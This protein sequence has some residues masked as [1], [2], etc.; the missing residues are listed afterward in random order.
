MFK[1]ILVHVPSTQSARPV[2]ECSTSLAAAL[3]A[4]LD[5]VAFG[6]EPVTAEL[7][8]EGAAAVAAVVEVQRERALQEANSALAVF[9]AEAKRSSVPYTCRGYSAMPAQAAE[10]MEGLSRLYDLTVASQP[11]PAKSVYDDVI[12]EA[13][14]FN[15]GGPVLVVPYIHR[16]PFSA[17]RIAI[18]W[19]G[20][21]SA[22]RA[23]R[24]A[25]PFLQQADAVDAL[26][27]NED[28][29]AVE[30]S[31]TALVAHLGRRGVNASAQR[32]TSERANVHN[33]ILSAVADFGTNLLVMGG[34]GHSRLREFVLGGV[35]RG[36]F[37]SMTIPVL[38]S[39]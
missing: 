17:K 19:D 15:S 20:S 6:Y 36:I 16:G 18:C 30:T 34:Y 23:V 12:P 1:H 28:P 22:A 26:S 24:D 32:L 14:L 5:A 27:V 10:T 37:Q 33:T 2:I 21:R 4:S 11:E 9:E 8:F 39:H 13:V 35:S 31:C 29:D 3:G 38:M 25:M 7:A